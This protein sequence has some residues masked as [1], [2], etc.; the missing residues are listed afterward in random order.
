A[1]Q[2]C[3]VRE[4]ISGMVVVRQGNVRARGIMVRS[5]VISK[6]GSVCGKQAE[7]PDLVFAGT[8]IRIENT[9]NMG[10][11][12]APEITVLGDVCGGVYHVT[13]QLTADRFRSA[14]NRNLSIVLRQDL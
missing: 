7:S 13:K 3:E 9:T 4:N 8:E 5:K 10:Q 2:H 14:E 12:K 11:F 1:S 6:W